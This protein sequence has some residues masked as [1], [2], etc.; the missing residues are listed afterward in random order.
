MDVC[1]SVI[2]FMVLFNSAAEDIKFI[3][4][5]QEDDNEQWVGRIWKWA[6]MAYLKV[7]SQYSVQKIEGIHYNPV[8]LVSKLVEV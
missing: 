7:L 3:K 6:G 2:W 8:R 5:D 1:V 4:W